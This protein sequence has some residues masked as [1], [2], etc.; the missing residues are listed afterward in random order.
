MVL[1]APARNLFAS[2]GYCTVPQ[3]FSPREVAGMRAELDRF[4]EEGLLRN[5]ACDNDGKTHSASAFNLQICPISNHSGLFRALKW[6]PR[7]IGAVQQLI[8]DPV[9][10]RL[11]QIFLKPAQHGA[12]TSW[13]QDNGYW[14]QPHPEKGTGMW[15]ALHDATIAN[16]TMHI[17]PGSHRHME[18]HE[19]DP[20]SDHHIYAPEVDDALALPIELPA[21]GVLFFNWGILHCTR[22]NTTDRARAGLALHFMNGDATNEGFW[23]GYPFNVRLTGD[24]ATGG[25]A[26][27]GAVVQG[28]W[29]AELERILPA[30]VTA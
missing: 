16:G 6:H 11:D 2:Q 4:V 24:Q 5:V 12:G 9:V 1:D 17:V 21:G 14:H 22:A 30:P 15:V 18:R 23:A 20:R 7:V 13:H 8:G 29:D 25:L 28:S 26:E 10:F 3:F 19:R 27:E